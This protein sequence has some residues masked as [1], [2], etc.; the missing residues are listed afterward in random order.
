VCRGSA[1]AGT[2]YRHLDGSEAAETIQFSYR[3]VS[4]ELDVS[5]KNAA[6]LD[7][8]LTKYIEAA[9]RTGGRCAAGGRGPTKRVAP[10][11]DNAAVRA[12]AEANGYELSSRGRIKAEIIE[13]YRAAGN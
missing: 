3:G 11:V 4:Y 6:A 8:A 5:E 1:G 12:W 2:A 7:K 10:G 9:R 13:A